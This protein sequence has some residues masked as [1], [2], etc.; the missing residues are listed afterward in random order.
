MSN[1]RNSVGHKNVR[2]IIQYF[3]IQHSVETPTKSKYSPTEHAFSATI[4][5]FDVCVCLLNVNEEHDSKL[6]RHIR[7]RRC[8]NFCDTC[9][10]A[11]ACNVQIKVK[12]LI[13]YIYI[14][15]I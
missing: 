10:V 13:T 11:I 4:N 7:A 8:H 6:C 12:V 3:I 14:I 5:L 2:M 1:F 15:S 9:Y